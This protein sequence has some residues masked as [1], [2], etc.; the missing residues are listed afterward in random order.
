M[1]K[2]NKQHTNTN[3]KDIEVVM[4]MYNLK[5]YSDDHS[6]TSGRLRQ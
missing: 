1:H 6:K 5:E 3:S 4:P 2:R